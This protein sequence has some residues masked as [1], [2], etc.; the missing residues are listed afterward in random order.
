[1]DPAA[2]GGRLIRARRATGGA[3]GAHQLRQDLRNAISR[4][5]PE[6]VR[7]KA[8]LSRRR[9]PQPGLPA[10][11]ARSTVDDLARQVCGMKVR[12]VAYLQLSGWRKHSS[13]TFRIFVYGDDG[14]EWSLIFKDA[15]IDEDETPGLTGLPVR[16]GP[17][18]H[19]IHT[20]GGRRLAPYLPEAYQV[21]E[22]EPGR[23]YRYLLADLARSGYDAAFPDDDVLWVAERLPAVHA[24]LSDVGTTV[25]AGE[26]V[27]YGHEFSA[28]LREMARRAAE[29]YTRRVTDRAVRRVL[30]RWRDV[31]RAHDVADVHDPSLRVL[32]H[33]DANRANSLVPADRK[34]PVKLVD[35]EWAGWALPHADLADLLK[36]KPA[37]LVARAVD[38]FGRALGGL[39]PDEHRRLHQWAR[40]EMRLFDLAF[41][42]PQHLGAPGT[43]RMDLP[44]YIHVAAREL[45]EATEALSS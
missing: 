10:G 29:T 37:A 31:E 4:V 20:G 24:E 45:G 8:R 12:D 6:V 33:G 26:L 19:R 42:I 5:V 35:W 7:R 32:R 38:R 40:L 18:E 30:E 3:V 17:P 1:M 2:R 34:G 13:G 21:D 39:T 43:S 44:R 16:P 41:L 28:K 15:L 14:D 27:S 23:H 22:V 9:S 11:L 25:P 36:G